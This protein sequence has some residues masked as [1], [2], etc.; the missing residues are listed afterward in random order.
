MEGGAAAARA[1]LTSPEF[2]VL[3]S[4]ES[5]EGREWG[6]YLGQ[7]EQAGD[8]YSEPIVCSSQYRCQK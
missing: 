4:S 3:A 7:Y 5:S 6:E 8:R 1:V 2:L